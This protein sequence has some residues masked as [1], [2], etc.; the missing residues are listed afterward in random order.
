MHNFFI[1]YPFLNYPTWSLCIQHY[2]CLIFTIPFH[3]RFQISLLQ[4]EKFIITTQDFPR[5]Q[6]SILLLYVQIMESL[7]WD[8]KDHLHGISLIIIQRKLITAKFLN[9]KSRHSFL[10]LTSKICV[11]Q[12]YK[13][14]QT[15]VFASRWLIS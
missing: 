5:V 10:K 4:Y 11:P 2:L 8:I 7:V 15:L 12:N 14:H 9:R 13:R 3:L 1:N 6:L